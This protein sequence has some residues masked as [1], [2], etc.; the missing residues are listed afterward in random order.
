MIMEYA[1]Q[2]NL[3]YHQ[4]TKNVFTELEAYKFFA[5]TLQGIKYLH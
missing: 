5:Q 2:G 3:F 4:N 1:E